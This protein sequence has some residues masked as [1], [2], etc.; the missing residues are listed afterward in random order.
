MSRQDSWSCLTVQQFLHF[1]N[2]EDKPLESYQWQQEEKSIQASWSCLTVQQFLRFCNW[3]GQAKAGEQSEP[4]P[5]YSSAPLPNG[6]TSWQRLSVKEFFSLCNWHSL[7]LETQNWQHLD[8]YSRLKQQVSEFFQLIPWEGNPEIGT[9]PKSAAILFLPTVDDV[10]PTF[11][12]L[13]DLF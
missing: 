9:L 6:H 3:E 2:W 10:E 1:C 12:D 5:L 7:P 4:L 8:P 13:S 11:T